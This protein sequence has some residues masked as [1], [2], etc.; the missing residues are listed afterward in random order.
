MGTFSLFG[1]LD[2]RSLYLLSFNFR[3]DGSSRFSP[4]NRYGNFFSGSAGWNL[5]NE[6]W[7]IDN[8]PSIS[9]L[10]LRASIGQLGNQD[11]GNYPWASII[12]RNYN[13]V[14]GEQPAS[15]SGYTISSRGNEN[16]KWESSTQ[17][18]VGF[19]IGVWH[20]KLSLSVDY[21][22][23][24]TS[25]MLIPVPLPLIGGSATTPF[26]ECRRG[27]EQRIELELTTEA[28][29]GL[30]MISM[31]ILRRLQIKSYHLAMVLPFRVEELIMGCMRL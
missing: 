14:F 19:D 23:K 8:I 20:D 25:D 18:D 13:Y 30:S 1:N 22:I 3:R 11:I 6:K 15:N 7:I 9:R 4:N 17:T 12:G 16:V 26:C 24:K 31:Q 2:Y 29:A 28:R 10:R 27:G 5:H 21:F